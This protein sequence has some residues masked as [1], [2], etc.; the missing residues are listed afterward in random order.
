MTH[1]IR[2]IERADPAQI[3]GLGECGVATVH[4]AM[5]RRG[6]M[7]SKMRPIQPDQA[8]AGS[9]ITVS[10]APGDNWMIHVALELAQPGDVLVV[11][12]FSPSDAGYFGDL[13]AESAQARGIAGLVIDA[14]V[15]DL[16]DLKQ[17]RFPVWSTAISAWGTVKETPGW[18]NVPVQCAGAI[19]RP[20]DVVVADDDGVAIVPRD[21]A[22]EVL[23]KARARIADEAEKRRALREGVLSMD[24]YNLRPGLVA[25]GFTY[26]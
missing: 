19:V 4:E 5:G 18:V 2:E 25:K 24:L 15:R 3:A 7:S 1:A 12:P 16:R 26:R 11:A 20:G 13:L 14:G 8:I 21:E 9:A 6:L 22:A 23:A 17:M 10:A